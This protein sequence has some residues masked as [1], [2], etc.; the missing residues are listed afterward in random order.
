MPI[1]APLGSPSQAS[2][3]AGQWANPPKATAPLKCRELAASHVLH[4]PT[5]SCSQ[6][7]VFRGQK[8]AISPVRYKW[9]HHYVTQFAM[10]R[11]NPNRYKRCERVDSNE[12]GHSLQPVPQSIKI[13]I[14]AEPSLHVCR[15]G[16]P[17]MRAIYT[18]I[19]LVF[20]GAT[21]IFALQ[22]RAPRD[23]SVSR[24]ECLLRALARHRSRL[25]ARDADRVDNRRPSATL[26]PP[27]L[28]T[29]SELVLRALR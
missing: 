4:R 23:D 19:L 13:L 5:L 8:S 20:L 21:A 26:D 15:E 10:V 7:C 14:R 24:S 18:L 16:G 2:S 27:G 1:S 3:I 6:N 22:N 29:T 25:S 28:G 9:S 17:A 12:G 11:L